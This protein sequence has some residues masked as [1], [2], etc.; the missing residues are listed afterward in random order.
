M[1]L[2]EHDIIRKPVV[3]DKAYKLHGTLKQVVLEVH[4]QANKVM[5]AKALK[6][7]FGVEVEK[8]RTMVKKGKLRQDKA[9]RKS[10]GATRKR[11]IITLKEGYSL[12]VLGQAEVSKG[13]TTAE[14]VQKKVGKED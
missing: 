4:P 10:V 5:I 8:V 1:A 6:N 11:A 13:A 12:D 7:L 2:S 3:T 9:K 14:P